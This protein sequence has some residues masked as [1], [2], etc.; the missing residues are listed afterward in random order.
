MEERQVTM[1]AITHPLPLP[2]IVLAT[3]NP[4]EHEGT[5]RLPEAQLDRFLMKIV[6]GY[7]EFDEEME[8]L[9]RENRLKS[10][11]KAD[12]INPVLTISDIL[13]LQS[14]TR[15]VS[16]ENSVMQYMARIVVNTRQHPSLYMGASP[17]ASVALLNTSKARALTLGRDFVIPDDVIYVAES[18]L[19]HRIILLPEREMEGMTPSQVIHQILEKIEIPR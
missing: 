9:S 15:S 7:P 18:V 11:E 12:N 10:D 5:Y 2:F 16:V 19:V 3:Q 14:L 13:E 17:R 6:M 4:V 8:I 1:D